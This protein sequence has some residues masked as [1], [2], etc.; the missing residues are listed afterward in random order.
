MP[1]ATLI[2]HWDAVRVCKWGR[3]RE[4]FGCVVCG[5]M[6][7]PDGWHA[8]FGSLQLEVVLGFASPPSHKRVGIAHQRGTCLFLQSV[9]YAGSLSGGHDLGFG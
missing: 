8:L 1:T 6:E 4:F 5:T 9:L 2:H 3:K 7:V